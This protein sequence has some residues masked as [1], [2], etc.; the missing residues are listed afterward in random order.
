MQL[1]AGAQTW[2]SVGNDAAWTTEAHLAASV[3]DAVQ[4]GNWQR[5]GDSK[6]KR[7]DPFPRPAQAREASEQ[8]DRT[9][10]RARAFLERQRRAQAQQ[11][12]AQTRPRDARGRFVKEA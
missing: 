10:L 5:A 9:E 3:F 8:V 7:P 6:A 12:P 11:Q 4:I 2:L 1:P